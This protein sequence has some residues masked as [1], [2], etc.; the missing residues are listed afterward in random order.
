MRYS[1]C[2]D[3]TVHGVASCVIEINGPCKQFGGGAGIIAA[4]ALATQPVLYAMLLILYT[5]A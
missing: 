2:C 3:A 4:L 1:S 5:T